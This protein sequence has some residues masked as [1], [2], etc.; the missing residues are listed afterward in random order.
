MRLPLIPPGQLTNGQKPLYER[1]RRQIES[2]HPF[3]T[4]DADGSLLGPWSVLIHEPAVGHAHAGLVDALNS[5]TALSPAAKQVAILAVG[6]RFRAAYELYA[7]EAV[8]ASE[9]LSAAKV[10]A[11]AAGGRP[12]DLAADEACA[13]DVALALLDG[14]ILPDA[15]YHAALDLIGQL[16][17]NQLVF[18]VGAYALVSIILNA[19]DVPSEAS[20]PG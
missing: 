11:L 12:S 10:T 3:K 1:Y 18:V 5:L 7:H 13:F 20:K 14:G 6:A 15:T 16:A 19:F 4:V 2:G 17:L 9:G 8:A